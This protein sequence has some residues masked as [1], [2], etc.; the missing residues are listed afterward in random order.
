MNIPKEA[1]LDNSATTRVYPEVA[2]EVKRLMEDEYGN[3]SS[4]H[5]RGT[6][7]ERVFAGA[8]EELAQLLG[9]KARGLV[10]T[11]GGTE[12]NN[13]AILGMARR[14]RK[15]GNH[16]I[17]S[18]VEHSSVLEPFKMLETEGFQ[19]TFLPPNEQGFIEPEAVAESVTAQTL[20]VSI[21]HVNNETGAVMPVSLIARAVRQKNPKTIVHV[22]A[23]Q[24]FTKV[25]LAPAEQDLDAVSLSAHK[26]HGP[27]G[28]GAL[29]LRQGLLAEPLLAGGGQQGEIR[30]G[31]ENIPGI[32]GMALAAQISMQHFRKQPQLLQNFRQQMLHFFQAE[33]SDCRINGPTGQQAASHILNISLPGLKGEVI[34]HALEE[35]GIFVSTGSACHSRSKEPSHVLKAMNLD[36]EAMEGAIRLSFSWMN[37]EEEIRYALEKSSVVLKELKTFFQ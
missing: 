22:D 2:R 9:V 12:S 6:T 19:V 1:Y 26:F 14:N 21:M 18:Q 4:L 13:L 23:A 24:S 33:H 37:T 17:T 27:K 29:Y 8:Q 15:R 7:A 31:T 11:S 5:R 28:V 32:A 20:L 35:H 30:P 3:P 25:P 10:F 36:P 16:L 34:L